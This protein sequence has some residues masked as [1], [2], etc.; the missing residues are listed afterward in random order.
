MHKLADH[1]NRQNADR[2]IDVERVPPA[3]GIRQPAAQRRTQHRCH[4]NAEAK[5]SH[6][7]TALLRREAFQQNRLRQRLQRAAAS[8]LHH[9]RQQ[10]DPQRWRSPTPERRK[11]EDDH[12]GNQEPLAP[13]A[14]REPVAGRKHHRVRDQVAGQHP[15]GF[16]IGSRQR[17]SDVRQR[18]GRNRRVQHFHESGQHH[19]DGRN[20]WIRSRNR[21]RFDVRMRWRRSPCIRDHNSNRRFD[22]RRHR[23]PRSDASD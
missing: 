14:Q 15:G 9:A 20:P 6:R 2:N 13:E 10:Q 22:Q 4:H 19:G 1:E 17:S 23:F 5:K 12:T 18:H 3:I 16:R 7:R 21:C 11:S 8:A